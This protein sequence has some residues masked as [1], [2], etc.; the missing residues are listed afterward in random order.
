[1]VGRCGG[2]GGC[3]GL[4][5]STTGIVIVVGEDLDQI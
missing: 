4:K 1:M 5:V 3:T 2:G